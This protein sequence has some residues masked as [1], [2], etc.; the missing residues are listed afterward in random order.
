MI[1]EVTSPKVSTPQAGLPGELVVW[2]SLN[3][4]DAAGEGERVGTP[5]LLR[6]K[7]SAGV[8]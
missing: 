3:A 5:K 7:V 1:M 6:C 4:W 8:T 2:F